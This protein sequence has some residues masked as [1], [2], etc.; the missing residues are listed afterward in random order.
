M[1]GRDRLGAVLGGRDG[2]NP[3]SASSAARM[4]S[5]RSAT[6]FA[7]TWT[8]ITVWV[9]MS[10]SRCSGEYTNAWAAMLATRG[11]GQAIS[12]IAAV[13]SAGR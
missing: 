1:D 12:R 2:S 6:S 10:C 7:S 13:T 5:A 11:P 9:R 8:P 4:L 3:P